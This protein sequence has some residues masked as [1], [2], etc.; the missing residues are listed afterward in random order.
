M[1]NIIFKSDT[2]VELVK[3]SANDND[4]I[5]SAQ[6]STLG[7]QTLGEINADPKRK[8]GLIRFLLRERHMSPFE[9]STFTFFINAPIFVFRELMRH[10]T[11]SYNE[12]SGR[13]KELPPTF[14]TPTEDRK[15]VQVGKTGNYEFVDGTPE[16]FT[17]VTESIATV[18]EIAYTEYRKMLDA[19]IA[20]EV[21]R[22]VLPVNLYSQAYMTVNLRNLMHFLSLRTI[23][24][25]AAVK[26]YPQRE[27]EMV[28]EKM[29]EIFA[30]KMPI[31]Y[32][33]FN[34]YGRNV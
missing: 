9:H 8:A 2:D 28:A 31:T 33:A 10:R 12:A 19:G 29:E 25:N 5:W 3:C 1:S 13:Y 34:E 18:S 14:Y 6:V 27:I 7:E 11:A 23:N 4:I 21:A 24:E 20:K 30:E 15:L 22:M 26:S 32:A 16:Q 17:Q